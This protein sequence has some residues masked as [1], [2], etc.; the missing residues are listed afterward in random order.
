MILGIVL[1]T[2]LAVLLIGGVAWFIWY[3]KRVTKRKAL[4]GRG[5]PDD[6]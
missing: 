2:V 5:D 6:D 1:G 3:R 4:A